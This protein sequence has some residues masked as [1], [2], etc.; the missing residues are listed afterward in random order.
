MDADMRATADS[1]TDDLAPM[2]SSLERSIGA[3]EEATAW[4][5]SAGSPND[6]LAGANP[7]LQ[8]FG[9]VI[10]GWLLARS[11]RAALELLAGGTGDKTFLEAKVATARFYSNQLLPQAEGLL[12]AVT[13]GIDEL[14]AI[15][16]EQL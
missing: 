3:L 8:M 12:P 7:Y 5:A 9:T 13:A 10:G 6:A 15:A 16:P 11:A 2:G 14:V 4:L 1:L